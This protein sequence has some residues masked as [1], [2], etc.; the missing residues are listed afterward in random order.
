MKEKRWSRG[1]ISKFWDSSFKKLNYS[2]QPITQEET[3]TWLAM[4][5]DYVKS[6][7][8][9]MYDSRNPMPDWVEN[10]KDLLRDKNSMLPYKN[11]T[12]TFYRMDTLEIM[13]VHTD[14]Y[15]TYI[16]L[17]DAKPENI[18]RILVMLE[19]W[20]PG[21]YL[22]IDGVG[23]TSWI[24]GDYF[25]WEN[26]VPHAASNIGVD[27]R[28]TLQITCEEVTSEDIWQSLHW[29]NV[30]DLKNKIASSDPAIVKIVE[31]V[32]NNDGNPMFLYMFNE[33]IKE[34]ETI[35][36]KSEVTDHLNK[37]GVDIY[38]YE[39]LCSYLEFAEQLWKPYGTKHNKLF[40]SEFTGYD[41]DTR[42]RADELDSIL[43]YIKN[44]NLTNVKV[45]TC[46][47]DV[48]KFYPYYTPHM[49]LLTDDL[50]VRNTDKFIPQD[51]APTNNFT[52]K[53]ICPNWRYT[54]H[55]HLITAYLAPLDS[56]VSWYYRADLTKIAR[57]VWTDIFFWDQEGKYFKN[58]LLGL[59][60]LNN[61][62]PLNLD[63][64]VADVVN[65]QHPYFLQAFPSGMIQNQS[66]NNKKTMEEFYK[67][68][69]VAVVNESRFAQP[70]GNYSEKV[71][72]PMFY[73]RPF[74]LAAPPKTLQF[75]REEGFKTFNGFWDESYDECTVHQ[76]RL[77]KIFD[78]ID[79]LNKKTYKELQDM[80]QAMI[81]ILEHNR[82][83][84]ESK[85]MPIDK[86]LYGKANAN[87]RM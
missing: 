29:F 62:A 61:N 35:T 18:R 31:S 41:S 34:L 85:M 11:M 33:R 81:P 19:G 56:H 5:Y 58:L 64:E 2:R 49:E 86:E 40:Y 36:H 67:D 25:I 8:G 51:E 76:E 28:Y 52:K 66:K 69:F 65:I 22:E 47:Y 10:F 4:G 42:M 73:K 14:H 1:H 84:V 77:F 23:I 57:Q 6:F 24:A 12:F 13:P 15:R 60:Y 55:R 46:D 74:I 39:P 27:P 54:S 82:I 83:L 26:D 75:L 87:R 20:K 44:N 16:K 7:T 72:Q 80:Y 53:F 9:S 3:D 70:T 32:Y 48:S 38:L 50:F 45:H 79:D 68:A 63:L 71:Y 43:T 37:V 21:H 17:H 59:E 78:L 30:P